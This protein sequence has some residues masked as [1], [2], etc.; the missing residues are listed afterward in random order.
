MELVELMRHSRGE[1][2]ASLA[3]MSWQV[4]GLRGGGVRHLIMLSPWGDR[5]A[6]L[7]QLAV[8]VADLNG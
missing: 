7:E 4:E 3:S 5:G 1:G 2:R 8:S 6:C